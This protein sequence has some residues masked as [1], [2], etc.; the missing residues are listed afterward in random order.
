MSW[1]PSKNNIKLEAN[2][3]DK[4][5]PAWPLPRQK[6]GCPS[7]LQAQCNLLQLAKVLHH[8][9]PYRIK[10]KAGSGMAGVGYRNRI[11]SVQT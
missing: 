2:V 9:W 1:V 7:Q 8:V 5:V 11:N 10:A 6:G 4:K 3:T